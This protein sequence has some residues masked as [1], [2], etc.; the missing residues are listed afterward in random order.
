MNENGKWKIIWTS[1]IRKN[2]YQKGND[3]NCT[4]ARELM[5]KVIAIDPFNGPAYNALAWTYI[6][7]YYRKFEKDKI[8]SNIQYAIELEKD[9]PEYNTLAAYYHLIY[10]PQLAI[11]TWMRGIEY[12]LNETEKTVL[13][14]NIALSYSSEQDYKN[15]EEFICKA[16]EIDSSDTFA[17]YLYGNLMYAQNKYKD[18]ISYYEKAIASKKMD[19]ALQTD[20][21]GSYAVCCYNEKLYDTAKEYIEKALDMEPDNDA[22][23][24]LYKKILNAVK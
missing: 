8:V 5:E 10:E 11:S 14:A 12:C 24:I 19:K 21:Y 18:A 16:L 17:L 22:Y 20:L 6:R 13:Y 3:G 7:D 1:S 2:A 4:E 23:K 9:I 15:A